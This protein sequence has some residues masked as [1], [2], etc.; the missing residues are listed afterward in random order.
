MGYNSNF[1]RGITSISGKQPKLHP[2]FVIGFS[3]GESY[4][5]IVLTDLLMNTG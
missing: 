4:F 3:N 1:I 2:Y 5:S